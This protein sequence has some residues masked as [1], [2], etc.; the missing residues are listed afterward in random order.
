MADTVHN[1][2]ARRK[3]R[4]REARKGRRDSADRTPMDYSQQSVI[5][6]GCILDLGLRGDQPAE[7]VIRKAV[8]V[9][10]KAGRVAEGGVDEIV[11][12]FAGRGPNA[13]EGVAMLHAHH[14][15]VAG[16]AGVFGWVGNAIDFDEEPDKDRSQGIF[17]LLSSGS[18]E[19]RRRVKEIEDALLERGAMESVRRNVANLPRLIGEVERRQHGGSWEFRKTT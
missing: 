8:Q 18:V 13:I 12:G 4:T 15:S 2:K 7:D 3:E 11:Q 9:L 14:G 1:R 6:E 5:P 10:V 17:L 19:D 16:V